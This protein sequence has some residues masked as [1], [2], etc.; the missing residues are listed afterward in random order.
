[1]PTEVGIRIVRLRCELR[2]DSTVTTRD[3]LDE[4]AG[5][6]ELAMTDDL[7][8]LQAALNKPLAGADNRAVKKIHFHY[9][10]MPD[11]PSDVQETDFVEN[12]VFD[13]KCELLDA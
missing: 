4:W 6:L 5:A 2:A 12:L 10:E 9:V 13:V 8:A 3:S 1:M 7:D 11:D